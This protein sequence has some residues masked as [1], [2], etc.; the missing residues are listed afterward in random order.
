MLRYLYLENNSLSE[1]DLEP[2]SNCFELVQLD[3]SK[4]FISYLDLSPIASLNLQILNISDNNIT[5]VR[6]DPLVFKP[7]LQLFEFPKHSRLL[8][9]NA[10]LQEEF[11]SILRDW[12]ELCEVVEE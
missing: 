2:L 7:K 8:I 10:L 6:I 9:S 3:L 12:K 5:E 11:P 4:N 1:I